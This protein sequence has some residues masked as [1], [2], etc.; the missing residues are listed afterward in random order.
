MTH[1]ES[2]VI[3]IVVPTQNRHTYLAVLVKSMLAMR[4]QDFELIVHDNSS[5]PG[6][7]AAA[8]GE[9]CD[10]RLHYVYDSTPMSITQNFERAVSLAKG[11]YVC[12]IGDDDGV[13]E[14]VIELARWLRANNIDAATSPVPT[15]YWPGVACTLVG[16]QTTGMLRLPRY[17]SGIEIVESV[18]ELNSVLCSGGIRIGDLPSVYQG[19]VS[20]RALERLFD[21][22]GTRFP[23]MSPDMANAVGLT[24]VVERFARVSFP[25]VISG[26]CSVSGAAEGARHQHH[27]ELADR[28]FLPS[29]TAEHWPSQIPF[30]FSGPTLWAATLIQALSSTGRE[31]AVSRLRYD[32]LYAACHVLSPPMYRRRMAQARSQNKDYVTSVRLW[33]AIAWVWSLRMQA[34]FTNLLSRVR[35]RSFGKTQVVGIVDIEQASAYI[36]REFGPIPTGTWSS[37]VVSSTKNNT[38]M[39]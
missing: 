9:L 12:M 27:G 39:K 2:P 11:D 33:L 5:E 16:K 34:L 20:R 23:G 38:S 28:K 24:A 22:V 32:R 14:S 17:S 29:D 36:I 21:L 37:E 7:F 26:L 4:S 3:S 35:S 15:Y 13:T 19:I 10:S 1:A 25:V 8:V 30:Y 6:G 18:L 31:E